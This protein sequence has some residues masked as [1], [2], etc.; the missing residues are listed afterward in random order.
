VLHWPDTFP[1]QY[2]IETSADGV[3]WTTAATVLDGQGGDETV[4]FNAPN[5]RYVR[6]QGVQR[7]TRFGYSLFGFELYAVAGTQTTGTGLPPSTP[8]GTAS[9]SPRPGAGASPSVGATSGASPSDPVSTS[10]STGPTDG[11][12]TGAD[13]SASAGPPTPGA[14]E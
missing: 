4:H 1:A 13:P 6:M 10:P 2:R 11:S 5:V 9:A 7:G 3:N 8:G 14:A 12:T